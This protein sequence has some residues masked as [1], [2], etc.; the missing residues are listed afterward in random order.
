M[1][2]FKSSYCSAQCVFVRELFMMTYVMYMIFFFT[3]N[4][5]GLRAGPHSYTVLIFMK[6][7]LSNC[8]ASL[9]F[10]SILFRF[11]FYFLLL[12]LKPPATIH[13][14]DKSLS[15]PPPFLHIAC[16][17]PSLSDIFLLSWN[18]QHVPSLIK[19]W[20]TT[21]MKE[22]SSVR[23]REGERTCTESVLCYKQNTSHYTTSPLPFSSWLA[24]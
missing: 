12:C 5:M 2:C 15:V 3:C 4:C 16:A 1:K 13:H 8:L 18:I 22:R 10:I 24:S 9:P 23:K 14:L 19:T 7:L 21:V 6:I 11:A 17:H 20:S